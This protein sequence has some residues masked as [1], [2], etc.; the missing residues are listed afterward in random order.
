[1]YRKQHLLLITAGVKRQMVGVLVGSGHL[2]VGSLGLVVAHM[3]SFHP[4]LPYLVA[5]VSYC[6]FALW[7]FHSHDSPHNLS[8][9]SLLWLSFTLS[10]DSFPWGAFAYRYRSDNL[11]FLAQGGGQVE[12]SLLRSLEIIGITAIAVGMITSTVVYSGAFALRLTAVFHQHWLRHV[13]AYARPLAMTAMLFFAARAFWAALGTV[14]FNV[15]VY[16]PRLDFLLA[17]EKA[18]VAAL[19][20]AGG[21]GDFVRLYLVA[22]SAEFNNPDPFVPCQSS[23]DL[24][25]SQA[26]T[27][28]I[29]DLSKWE[30]GRRSLRGL[31]YKGFPSHLFFQLLELGQ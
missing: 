23:V 19:Q 11:W 1:M 18:P 4:G 27:S 24:W 16:Y 21:G 28:R 10:L 7:H 25:L 26:L 3:V 6:A 5:A 15:A 9:A 31:C 30:E 2:V 17:T 29:Q 14:A 20:V 8:W 13:G 12:A 22:P